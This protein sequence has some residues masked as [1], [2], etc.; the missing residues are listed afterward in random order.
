[1][2]IGK[3]ISLQ[4]FLLRIV[5]LTVLMVWKLSG[6]SRYCP[7]NPDTVRTIQKLSGQSRNCP[8]NSKNVRTIQKLSRQSRNCPDNKKVSKKFKNCPDNAETVPTIKNCL[9]NSKIFR[10]ILKLTRQS[11]NCLKDC[12]KEFC[13]SC[14]ISLSCCVITDVVIYALHPENFC[15]E[16]LAIRKVF[17]FSDSILVMFGGVWSM[18]GFV[19]WCL[20]YVWWCLVHVWWCLMNCVWWFLLM[21]GIC[22]VQDITGQNR[23]DQSPRPNSR[24]F[25]SCYLFFPAKL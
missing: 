17:A 18:L 5:R 8:D 7:D 22:L 10:T 24:N 4:K 19:W 13:H 15:G 16:N 2:Y 14:V 3:Y 25:C 12:F 6:Q 11:K 1:M 21:F 23:E 9:D 20:G